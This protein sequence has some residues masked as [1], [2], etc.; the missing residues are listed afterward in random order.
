MKRI[1]IFALLLCAYVGAQSYLAINITESRKGGAQ[2]LRLTG[3]NHRA[4]GLPKA[5]KYLIRSLSFAFLQA[6]RLEK[7]GSYEKILILLPIPFTTN[8]FP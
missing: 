8:D 1:L 4:T 3:R 7:E 6:S 5:S 2:S